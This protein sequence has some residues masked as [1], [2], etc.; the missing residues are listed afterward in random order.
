MAS[1]MKCDYYKA[2]ILSLLLLAGAI[3]YATPS[4]ALKPLGSQCS[5]HQ[6]CSSGRC[7]NRPQSGCVPQDGTGNSG[8]FCSTHQ[9]CRTGLC[10]ISQGRYTGVCSGGNHQ[11]GQQCMTR[12]DVDQGVVITGRIRMRPSGWYR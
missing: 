11:L 7:D 5:T 2:F 9:Q 8:E 4:F 3:L 12:Q 6:E 10:N 1:K